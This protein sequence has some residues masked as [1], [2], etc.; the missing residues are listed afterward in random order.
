MKPKINFCSTKCKLPRAINFILSK[1][2]AIRYLWRQNTKIQMSNVSDLLLKKGTLSSIWIAGTMKDK[3]GKKVI[4]QTDITSIVNQ[5]ME[6]VRVN[7]VLRLSGMLLKGLVVVYSK[8]TQYM[9]VDCEE[10]ISKIMQSFKPGAV[11]LP[12]LKK[13]SSDALT[14]ALD[15]EM[16]D[17]ETIDLNEW[18]KAQNPEQQYTFKAVPIE[19]TNSNSDSSQVLTQL[20]DLSSSSS[21]VQSS[22][23]VQSDSDLGESFIPL[24]P[25][26]KVNDVPLVPE[27]VDLPDDNGGYEAPPQFNDSDIESSE[28]SE[29]ADKAKPSILDTNIDLP[30]KRTHQRKRTRNSAVSVRSAILPQNEELEN[31]FEIA[32]KQFVKPPQKQK[33]DEKIE[34]LREIDDDIEIERTRDAEPDLPAPLDFDDD[35]T[36]PS[37]PSSDIEFEPRRASLSGISPNFSIEKNYVESPFPNYK[38]AIEPT[39]RKTVEDSITNDTIKTLNK[40]KTV[41]GEKGNITFDQAFGGSSRHNAAIS[42]YQMLVLRS[43]GTIDLKQSEPFGP[44][45]IYAGENFQSH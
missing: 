31:L 10:I 21:S 23:I 25:I 43:T 28:V 41:I 13:V 17:V 7:L 8:K 1:S 40:L 16:S 14:I 36:R 5:I 44:I 6:D 26:E 37:L 4:L 34:D 24:K 29:N 20:S 15:K 39:P 42:F 45:E 12:Q 9:L 33:D 3:L 11:N 2:R 18:I 32:K 35:D 27:W 30:D 19:F 38:F 22:Q